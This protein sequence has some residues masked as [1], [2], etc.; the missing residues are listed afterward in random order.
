MRTSSGAVSVAAVIPPT[1]CKVSIVRRFKE[2][3]T[4]PPATKCAQLF[5]TGAGLVAIED[6]YRDCGRPNPPV[7]RDW[8]SWVCE[9][10]DLEESGGGEPVLVFMGSVFVLRFVN[11]EKNKYYKGLWWYHIIKP[12]AKE[13]LERFNQ[14]RNSSNIFMTAH[15]MERD[16]DYEFGLTLVRKGRH[17]AELEAAQRARKGSIETPR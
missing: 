13:F 4:Y 7:S 8:S 14:L 9:S 5:A 1:L 10:G 11:S 16:R 2:K 3:G 17:L 6:A 12:L 15:A